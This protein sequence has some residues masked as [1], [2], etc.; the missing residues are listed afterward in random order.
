MSMRELAITE[1][2][3]LDGAIDAR[4]GWFAPTRYSTNG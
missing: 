3:A 2:V 1:N 4:E